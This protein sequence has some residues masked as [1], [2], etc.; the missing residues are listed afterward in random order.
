[1]ETDHIL[2]IDE[3]GRQDCLRALYDRAAHQPLP[4]MEEAKEEQ[5][6]GLQGTRHLFLN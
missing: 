2:N 6:A 4:Q 1:M 5:Q 3:Q